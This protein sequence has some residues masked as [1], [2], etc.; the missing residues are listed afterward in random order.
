MVTLDSVDFPGDIFS[1]I[2]WSGDFIPA[3]TMP[4]DID[5]TGHPLVG[6]WEWDGD[7][8]W[9]YI[10]NPDGTGARGMPDNRQTFYWYANDDQLLTGFELWT[11]TIQDNVLILE[12]PGIVYSYIRAADIGET[13]GDSPMAAT[14]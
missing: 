5:F 11:F 12:A 10:F 3:E 2:R 14:A 8:N 7:P 6:I 13:I 1:Y 4:R 9:I